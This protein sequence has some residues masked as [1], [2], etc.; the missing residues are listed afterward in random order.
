MESR[1]GGR[2]EEATFLKVD[3]KTGPGIFHYDPDFG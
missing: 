2:P 1:D 3:E